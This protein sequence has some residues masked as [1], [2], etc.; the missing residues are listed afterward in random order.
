[1]YS[2]SPLCAIRICNVSEEN[3]WDIPSE[4]G[5]A[6]RFYPLGDVAFPAK[7]LACGVHVCHLPSGKSASVRFSVCS[8]ENGGTMGLTIS[9]LFSRLFS[10]K[11]MRILMGELPS[12]F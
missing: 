12:L 7:R 11:Q 5:P 8:E 1:M 2:S 4:S 6:Y 10:K 9:N 3:Y